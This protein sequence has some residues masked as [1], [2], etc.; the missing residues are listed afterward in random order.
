MLKARC[1]CI[2][3]KIADAFNME[4]AAGDMEEDESGESGE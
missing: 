1:A 2:Y 4:D 3:T